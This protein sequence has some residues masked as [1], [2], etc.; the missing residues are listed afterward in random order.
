MRWF[1]L[2]D[3]SLSLEFVPI[4]TLLPTTE[5]ETETM[6]T[7]MTTGSTNTM[8]TAITTE[9]TNS[10]RIDISTGST[11]TMETAEI[12]VLLPTTRENDTIIT[13]NINEG[14]AELEAGDVFAI[15]F[16]I[17]VLAIIFIAVTLLFI[18]WTRKKSTRIS[19]LSGTL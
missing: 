15:I 1:P 10:M 19:K 18:Y 12:T 16:S 8:E 17:V 11:N 4:P 2:C 5:Q 3:T 14:S 9:T 13:A 7:D 6:G